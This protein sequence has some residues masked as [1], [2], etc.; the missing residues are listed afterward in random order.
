MSRLPH[1]ANDT[2]DSTDDGGSTSASR[3][4]HARL[5]VRRAITL[6]MA[7]GSVRAATTVDVSRI[8]LSLTTDK[9]VAPGSKCQ[10]RVDWT[11]GGVPKS[12]E[13]AAKGVYSS[14][15]G[16]KCFRI[17]L[18]FTEKGADAAML[19]QHLINEGGA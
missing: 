15:S 16:P 10:V 8:G 19:V 11:A 18:I 7:D 14:Y 2:S 12:A 9:P 17:G 3:R 13:I 6:T 4:T 5:A 1:L